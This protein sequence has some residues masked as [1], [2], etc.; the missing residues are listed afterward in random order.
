MDVDKFFKAA[1]DLY[2]AWPGLFQ[3]SIPFLVTGYLGFLW[4][5]YGVGKWAQQGE[6]TALRA[7]NESLRTINEVVKEKMGVLEERPKLASEQAETAKKEAE[8]LKAQ[9]EKLDR[10]LKADVIDASEAYSKAY[11]ELHDLISSLNV[12][13]SSVSQANTAISTT[14]GAPWDRG[15]KYNLDLN[16]RFLELDANRAANS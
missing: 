6:A 11:V 10:Q 2:S 3:Y 7:Q 5:G 14:L 13:A 9:A 15:Y 8:E 16:K 12:K 4:S 1:V